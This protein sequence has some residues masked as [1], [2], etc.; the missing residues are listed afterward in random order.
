MKAVFK[1]SQGLL[2]MPWVF[3]HLTGSFNTQTDSAKLN[4]RDR[5]R[6]RESENWTIGLQQWCDIYN[7]NRTYFDWPIESLITMTRAPNCY[8]EGL[9]SLVLKQYLFTSTKLVC[10]ASL[11]VTT[12]WTSSINFCFSSSSKCMYHFASLVF[13]ARFW[14]RINLIYKENFT[15]SIIW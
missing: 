15:Y 4:M 10:L 13:P 11:T 3:E 14:I 8:N 1:F 6:D 7:L 2:N 12:A 5:E 9:L